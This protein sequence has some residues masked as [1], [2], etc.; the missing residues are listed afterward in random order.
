MG[1]YGNSRSN[2]ASAR[3]LVITASQLA[4][5]STAI[6]RYCVH[7]VN[8][9]GTINAAQAHWPAGKTVKLPW[10][11]RSRPFPG[12]WVTAERVGGETGLSAV[13]GFSPY[14]GGALPSE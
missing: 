6:Q 13:T 9:D 10:A 7:S 14:G 4:Q 8:D 5:E 3:T 2:R 12:Q 1:Y 11:E